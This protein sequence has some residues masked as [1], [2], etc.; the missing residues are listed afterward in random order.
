MKKIM[1]LMIM[2]MVALV[3]MSGTCF[4]TE[5]ECI[6]GT[7]DCQAPA[8]EGNN[9]DG[10]TI[11]SPSTTDIDTTIDTTVTT[12]D[13]ILDIDGDVDV[14]VDTSQDNDGIDL[15]V[16]VTD[17]NV[18]V[19][20]GNTTVDSTTNTTTTTG[21][22][23][24]IS[25][26]NSSTQVVGDNNTVSTTQKIKYVYNTNNTYNKTKWYYKTIVKENEVP[27]YIYVT[28]SGIEDVEGDDTNDDNAND[29]TNTDIR[30]DNATYGDNNIGVDNQGDS[31]KTLTFLSAK[32]PE[33]YSDGA[34]GI[35]GTLPQTGEK[36]AGY[37]VAFGL[38]LTTIGILGYTWR[39]KHTTAD[40][41]K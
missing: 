35:Y 5:G 25:T 26:N 34:T 3:I 37:I 40:E 22:N 24:V 10:N 36:P 9:N 32:T 15:D 23:S 18:V 41:E 12:D 6:E 11:D 8:I 31:A 20:D 27:V 39:K 7:D 2:V 16:D 30:R 19:G 33:S 28:G 4:A 1:Y 29:N 21:D 17:T 14:N 13:D 38:I